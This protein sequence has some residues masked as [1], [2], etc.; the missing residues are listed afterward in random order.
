MKLQEVAV[1]K[2]RLELKGSFERT[3]TTLRL[4]SKVEL[5]KTKHGRV[6][7]GLT[8]SNE[9]IKD[10]VPESVAKLRDQ[11][12][13]TYLDRDINRSSIKKFSHK[14]MAEHANLFKSSRVSSTTREQEVLE[15]FYPIED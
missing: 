9:E 1:P 6:Y 15:N 5:K 2:G 4:N 8:S 3:L 10:F 13:F 14:G 12:V 11:P 7:Y